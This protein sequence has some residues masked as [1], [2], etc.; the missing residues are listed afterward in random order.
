MKIAVICA[1][2]DEIKLLAKKMQDVVTATECGVAV[3][4]GRMGKHEVNL[5]IGGIGKANAA[6]A[7]QYNISQFGCDAILNIGLAGNCS[8]L[9]LGGAVV[10]D[11]L[12]YHDF[13]MRIAAIDP[14]H[15]EFFTPDEGLSACAARALDRL[16]RPWI[17]G[18]VATGDQF[19]S[20]NAVKAD[21]VARTGCVCVEMEGAAVAHIAQKN[22]M[23]FAEIK[24]MS[25]NADECADD[26][27]DKTISLGGYCEESSEIIRT[28]LELL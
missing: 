14:P 20:D 1:M 25:D 16:G 2:Q 18:T 6:A 21:I 11:R 15:A 10:A 7:T 9:P 28:I 12:V 23:P 27:F 17:R 24:V 13:E 19:I 26:Q 3:T 5:C 22:G 4:R 8:H